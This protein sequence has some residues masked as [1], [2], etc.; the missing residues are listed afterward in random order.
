MNEMKGRSPAASY[1]PLAIWDVPYLSSLAK[2]TWFSLDL[3]HVAQYFSLGVAMEGLNHLF[4]RIYGVELAV[5]SPEEG[6]LWYGDVVKLAVRHSVELLGHIYC[7]FFRR[8]GKPLQ[9]CHFTIRGG[10]VRADGGYQDPVVVLMLNLTP[11]TRSTPT[12]LT[13]GALDNLFHEMGHAMH[14]MLGRTKYQH[15]TG[16]RCS[17]D[18]AE[19]QGECFSKS[20][21]GY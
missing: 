5:E 21:K 2:H 8:P 9:D 7:D 1:S 3:E 12:L 17:T 16:T 15:V 10:R 20:Y 11:P 19:V 18:F 13:P 6:E 4:Q 14:S